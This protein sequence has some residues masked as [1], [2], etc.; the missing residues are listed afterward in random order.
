MKFL[1]S[2]LYQVFICYK[3]PLFIALLS[4]IIILFFFSRLAAI[5]FPQSRAAILNVWELWNVWDA[6]HY[7]SI[8]SSG[9]QTVGDAANFLAFLPALPLSIFIS[10]LI[11]QT[12]YLISG[13]I[14]S[15]IITI[16]L[17]VM[18]YKLALMDY[19]KKIATLAVLMLFIFPTS[20]FL[21]I[22]YAESLL[23]LM[24]VAAFYFVRKKYYWMSFLCIGIATATKIM[25]LALIPAIF[26][27]ILVFDR[28]NLNSKNILNKLPF[29]FFGLILSVS[30]FLIYLSINYFLW[31]DFWYFTVIQKQHW[32]ENFSPLGQGLVAAYHSLFW[33]SGIEKIMLGYAQIIAFTFALFMSVYVL[34]KVRISYGIFMLIGLFSSY[35]MSFW[36][37][38]PRFIIALFPMYIVIAS[39]S[40]NLIFRYF[41]MIIS[42]TLLTILSFIFMQHGPVL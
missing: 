27:E 21:H 29:L 22:P 37:S 20:F 14:V 28:E 38:M 32:F 24:A 34:F 16:L 7:I 13:Y 11:F 6:P 9:Y 36:M 3:T 10:K 33:R 39:F 8:A 42:M 19:P 23:A 35:S 25:G 15:F 1:P 31:G 5:L 4:E 26:L 12:N 40:N 41:W 17:A 2:R 18:L 30:G